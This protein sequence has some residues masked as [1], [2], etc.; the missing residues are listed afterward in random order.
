MMIFRRMWNPRPA[1]IQQPVAVMGEPVIKHGT[2]V[3]IVDGGRPFIVGTYELGGG[4]TIGGLTPA[5]LISTE[6]SG[7]PA[8]EGPPGDDGNAKVAADEAALPEVA[9]HAAEFASDDVPMPN[10][11][12]S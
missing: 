6:P 4:T 2:P 5:L 1:A 9:S 10:P 12:P 8:P 7:I 11:R 3:P